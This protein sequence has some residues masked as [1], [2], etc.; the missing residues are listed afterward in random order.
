MFA[1][2]LAVGGEINEG[3]RFC[4]GFNVRGSGMG[5][6]IGQGQGQGMGQGGPTFSLADAAGQIIYDKTVK[7][8]PELV[9]DD[10]EIVEII[11][12]EFDATK[13]GFGVVERVIK[14]ARVKPSEPY[15]SWLY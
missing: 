5:R 7:S 1:I 14:V 11:I 3:A 10:P 2:S 9:Q 6:G 12:S 13:D 4:S 8:Y 15:R